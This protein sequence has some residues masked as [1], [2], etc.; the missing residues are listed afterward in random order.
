MSF[1]KKISSAALVLCC[2]SLDFFHEISRFTTST[3]ATVVDSL[4]VEVSGSRPFFQQLRATSSCF[5]LT[6]SFIGETSVL[7]FLQP[8][9]LV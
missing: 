1:T 7:E 8:F 3:S 4:A 9:F 5:I 2:S 6:F